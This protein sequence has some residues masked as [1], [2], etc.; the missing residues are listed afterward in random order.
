M[1]VHST[2][3][4]AT[5]LGCSGLRG[6]ALAPS[7]LSSEVQLRQLLLLLTATVSLGDTLIRL[8]FMSPFCIL[9]IPRSEK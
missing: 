5:G 3:A 1:H 7:S 2:A 9:F 8:L 6:P 4:R